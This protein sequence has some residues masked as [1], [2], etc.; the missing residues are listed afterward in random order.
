MDR[1]AVISYLTSRTWAMDP[2]F[3]Q[4]TADRVATLL[5]AVSGEQLEAAQKRA[6][7]RSRAGTRENPGYTV[8]KGVAHIPVAGVILK[9]VP[10]IFDLFGMP[11]TSTV[12]TQAALEA[13]LYDDAV[14]S[15]QLD[16]DSPGGSMDGL[17]EL[18]GD[19][20]AAG[21]LKPI[22]AHISG[23][24]ASAAYWLASQTSNVSATEGS[25][26]GSI[27]VYS[28]LED[29]SAQKQAEGVKVHVIRSHELKG[30]AVEGAPI[31][32][33]KLADEQRIVDEAASMFMA[34]VARGRGMSADAVRE[35]AT[36]QVWFAGAALERRLIDGI[37]GSKHAQGATPAATS[38]TVASAETTAP[39]AG[40]EES[41]METP[42]TTGSQSGATAEA[43]RLAKLEAENAA[44]KASAAQVD[45]QRRDGLVA[46]YHDRVPPASLASVKKVGETYG[47]DLAGF[48]AFLKGMPVI[49]RAQRES[50][51]E[52]VA[53]AASTL[54]ADE[55]EGERAFAR[56]SGKSVAHL[57]DSATLGEAVDHVEYVKATDA[58]GKVVMEPRAVL[59][60][61]SRLTRAELRQ[62]LGLKSALAAIAFLVVSAFGGAAHAA[63]SAARATECKAVSGSATNAFLMKAS[64]TIY[65]GGLVMIDSNGVALPAAASA[66]NHGVVGVAQET[67][68]S[69][70]SGS[71]WIRTSTNVVCK[72]AASSIAQA[73]VGSLMYAS[74]DDTFDETQAANQPVAGILIQYVSATVGW[75]YVS[76]DIQARYYYSATDPLTLTGD[77]TLSGGAS[78]LTFTDSASSVVLPDNDTTALLIGSTGLLNLVTFDTG[79]GT[80]TVLITG[81][82]GQEAFK[83][84]TGTTTLT[85][86]VTC[87][88]G[89]GALTFTSSN[90]SILLAD[91]D[92]SALDIGSTGATSLVRLS[93]LDAG[94]SVAVTGALSVSAGLVTP[95]L[96]A[97]LVAG[98]CTAGT[99][100]VDNTGT[101]ELCRCND[102]GSAYDC[103]SVTTANGPTD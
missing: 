79:D 24:A 59:K 72:F 45:A 36:G 54:T 86:A 49:T 66:S 82:T 50:V 48:E 44:L 103:I 84:G 80:E 52:D 97:N 56:L 27:G 7:A 57:H 19:I 26:V 81:T 34:A 10:C 42:K 20:T 4:A 28:V 64:T 92:A 90:A 83:V 55:R 9:E 95:A 51:A 87:E 93:T 71:Y 37:T 8:T 98:A 101:R 102:A 40:A 69:A 78:G 53:A 75:L 16:V 31:S 32:A 61:G 76:P 63:L 96:E 2:Q 65:A 3:L 74:A 35:L 12:D 77:L 46:K 99:W 62:R 68:T 25:L 70:A 91:N 39:R 43:D 1:S 73:N 94:G 29:T 41:S 38:P 30:A 14:R 11:A 47:A 23:M 22:T 17:V 5:P 89:A 33:A 85:E 100:K 18:A 21:G 6:A 15:I 58:S 13:A 67:K 60:D 88:A